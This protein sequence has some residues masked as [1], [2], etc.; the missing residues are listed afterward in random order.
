[1][2]NANLRQLQGGPK[3]PTLSLSYPTT[4]GNVINGA[5]E[6]FQGGE[7]SIRL[8]TA[9]CETPFSPSVTF[10]VGGNTQTDSY[11]YTESGS[12]QSTVNF[13][14]DLVSLDNHLSALDNGSVTVC[15]QLET[16]NTLQNYVRTINVDLTHSVTID[17]TKVAQPV[18]DVALTALDVVTNL[19]AWVC[20]ET[21]D[22]AAIVSGSKT[23]PVVD[24]EVPGRLYV[25]IEVTDGYEI[26]TG[27]LTAASDV[28]P[29]V[30]SKT[31]GD[32]ISEPTQVST[33]AWATT[34]SVLGW[35]QE[36]TMQT[37]T[38]KKNLV[39]VSVVLPSNWAQTAV[40]SPPPTSTVTITV[41]AQFD[42]VR[43]L[44]TVAAFP[45]DER[46]ENFRHLRQRD[47]EI[48]VAQ[49]AEDKD[50]GEDSQYHWGRLRPDS[51][52]AAREKPKLKTSIFAESAMEFA[53]ATTTVLI[54]G[55]APVDKSL[56]L[57]IAGVI[58]GTIL[59]CMS[60]CCFFLGA[61]WIRRKDNDE[62]DHEKNSD[63]GSIDTYTDNDMSSKISSGPPTMA[64]IY[65]IGPGRHLSGRAA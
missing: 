19:E 38:S 2:H 26:Q 61:F 49:D 16:V 24:I 4:G 23:S 27:Q 33:G 3:A 17:T 53:Q 5:A 44:A 60:C 62:E 25:C 65:D 34:A 54:H 1:M 39:R 28:T 36:N 42:P 11:T 57:P 55:P 52:K 35:S 58:A 13:D 64:F 20:A 43:R 63:A 48:I 31:I 50:E 47:D 37:W 21:S 15:V 14:I 46:E 51:G 22:D 45:G 7:R 56:S 40:V 10:S 12:A 6:F 18:A 32:Y 59:L 29:S 30:P 41:T 8:F 9:D